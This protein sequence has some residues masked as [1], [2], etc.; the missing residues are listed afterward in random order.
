MQE[1]FMGFRKPSREHLLETKNDL[2]RAGRT[3][4]GHVSFNKVEEHAGEVYVVVR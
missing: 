1:L 3:I 4:R 2:E